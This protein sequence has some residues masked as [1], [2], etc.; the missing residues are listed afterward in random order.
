MTD[1][2]SLP[3]RLLLILILLGIISGGVWGYFKWF[4]HDV[5]EAHERQV[6]IAVGVEV[7]HDSKKI[8]DVYSAPASD[9]V[10]DSVDRLLEPGASS[11]GLS[12]DRFNSVDA[13]GFG[14][15]G[16]GLGAQDGLCIEQGCKES[17]DAEP[18]CEMN[19]LDLLVLLKPD[20]VFSCQN[21]E[22]LEV[23]TVK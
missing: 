13:E 16:V 3:Q 8:G 22:W 12:G 20:A 14:T 10:V 2:L 6:S 1:L 7:E 17:T 23:D 9:A 5:I 19:E 4:S 21:G 18:L 15:G 11:P